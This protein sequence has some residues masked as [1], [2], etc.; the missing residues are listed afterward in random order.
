[1]KV[2][3]D[4]IE[5]LSL[6]ANEDNFAEEK[7]GM[8]TSVHDLLLKERLNAQFHSTVRDFI[9]AVN[10]GA[11]REQYI[12][13][14]REFISSFDRALLDTEDAEHVAGNFEKIM[15]C[16]GLESSDGILNNWMYGFEPK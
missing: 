12:L 3:A 14:L 8:Y 13:L 11:T 1:M 2:K 16:I 7:G 10:T 9:N 6:L 15:D 4:A 5:K